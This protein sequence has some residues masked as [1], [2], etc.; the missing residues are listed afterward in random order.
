M[1]SRRADGTFPVGILLRTGLGA[2]HLAAG[3]VNGD[4]KADLVALNTAPAGPYY[5]S[6]LIGN[7]DGT[8]KPEVRVPRPLA[9]YS[10]G[11]DA[12]DVQVVDVTGD[13]KPDILAAYLYEGFQVASGN[14]DGTFGPFRSIGGPAAGPMSVGD[15]N[16]DGRPDVAF[17]PGEGVQRVALLLANADSTFQE[18]R[19]PAGRGQFDVF[20]GD[21][22]R[23]ARSDVLTLNATARN[24]T[25]L[26]HPTVVPVVAGAGLTGPVARGKS[27]TVVLTLSKR[28]PVLFTIRKGRRVLSRTSLSGGVGANTFTLKATRT[29]ARGTYQLRVKAVTKKGS[30]RTHSLS[31]LVK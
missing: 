25:A 6:V 31:L 30:S 26:I 9:I 21:L 3:D 10:A 15:V 12:R 5:V 24:L 16:G 28:S 20:V 27:G 19:F 17:S 14:G 8:F 1:Y 4:S 23:D 2:T 18:V 13:A 7:G 29:L 11:G 22:D